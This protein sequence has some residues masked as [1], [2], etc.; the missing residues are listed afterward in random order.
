MTKKDTPD[1]LEHML[2]SLATT[3]PLVQRLIPSDVMFALTDREKFSQSVMSIS[4]VMV[5]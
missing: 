4:N 1:S 2:S 5:F 3:L